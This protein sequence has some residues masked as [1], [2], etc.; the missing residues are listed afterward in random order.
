MYIYICSISYMDWRLILCACVCAHV[1][2]GNQW[3]EQT[4]CS[5]EFTCCSNSID[6]LSK[7][8]LFRWCNIS[9]DIIAKHLGISL[10]LVFISL[11]LR[12]TLPYSLLAV[13]HNG[14]GLF[15]G[16]ISFYTYKT[17]GLCGMSWVLQR[18]KWNWF[19]Q[20]GLFTEMCATVVEI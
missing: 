15:I 5:G 11:L 16:L 17:F 12:T 19:C 10:L 20:L 7:L 2:V 9:P 4:I 3:N 13:S 14:L 1:R 6:L 8:L 18:F